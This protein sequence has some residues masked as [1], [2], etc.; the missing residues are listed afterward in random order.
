MLERTTHYAQPT[1]TPP[2]RHPDDP[3]DPCISLSK[4]SSPEE[5]HRSYARINWIVS[6][7]DAGL[8]RND[9]DRRS[10]TAD[11]QG[12]NSDLPTTA[13]DEG[14]DCGDAYA[15]LDSD[16]WG[17]GADAASSNAGSQAGHTKARPALSPNGATDHRASGSGPTQSH[18][19]HADEGTTMPPDRHEPAIAPRSTDRPRPEHIVNAAVSVDRGVMIRAGGGAGSLV[20]DDGPIHMSEHLSASEKAPPPAQD[21]EYLEEPSPSDP[22]DCGELTDGRADSGG[23]TPS[24]VLPDCVAT[25]CMEHGHVTA[26]GPKTASQ[27][28]T[29]TLAD[30]QRRSADEYEDAMN[31]A[32]DNPSPE[33]DRARELALD[34][35]LAV[36]KVLRGGAP[37]STLLRYGY[38]GPIGAPALHDGRHDAEATTRP[39]DHYE[40][41]TVPSSTYRPR[42][43]HMVNA[44]VPV[45]RGVMIRAGSG[46]GSLVSDDGLIRL[47]EHLSA[48][49][50]APPPRTG[51]RVLGRTE[52]ERPGRPRRAD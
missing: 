16:E 39:T 32:Y 12:T 10:P 25:A 50:K 3:V 20:S 44:A 36:I 9:A 27:A 19:G 23:A 7:I 52:P 49:E 26:D 28:T 51:P 38:P 34:R 47:S 31:A 15:Y 11:A 48:S 21:R 17:L 45:G 18:N 29:E 37:L 8:E 40:P 4:V 22:A 1:S 14:S 33:L 30:F 46:A 24:D 2:H 43:E 5:L 42:P 6:K 35:M 13:N 41:A